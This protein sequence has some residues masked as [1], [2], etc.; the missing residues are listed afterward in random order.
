[1]RDSSYRF[2]SAP[3]IESF[4]YQRNTDTPLRDQNPS[5]TESFRYRRNINTPV[6]NQSPSNGAHRHGKG[7]GGTKAQSHSIRMDFK[8]QPSINPEKSILPSI[9]P[10]W[11]PL[12]KRARQVRLDKP[13]LHLVSTIH[14]IYIVLVSFLTRSKIY[15]RKI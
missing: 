6:R 3:P 8:A 11:T 14:L 13:L 5:N 4:S 12:D 9:E 7:R 1:M 2:L 15:V 10:T